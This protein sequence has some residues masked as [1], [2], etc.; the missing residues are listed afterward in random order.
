MLPIWLETPGC[1]V[2]GRGV[3]FSGWSGFSSGSRSKLAR[4][5]PPFLGGITLFVG[6][7]GGVAS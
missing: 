6:G 3:T 5:T 7:W 4:I 2:L 1:Q